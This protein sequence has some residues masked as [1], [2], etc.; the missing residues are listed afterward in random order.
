MLYI[1]LKTKHN[2]FLQILRSKFN[3]SKHAVISHGKNRRTSFV[4]NTLFLEINIGIKMTE[5]S[6]NYRVR[7]H[8]LVSHCTDS[9]LQCG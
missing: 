1:Q 5:M 6:Q 2:P 7:S 3:I 8:L 9:Q 4:I